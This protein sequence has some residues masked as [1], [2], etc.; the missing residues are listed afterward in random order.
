MITYFSADRLYWTDGYHDKIE[1]TDLNGG[2]RREILTDSSSHMMS[3]FVGGPY[4]YYTAW[5]RQ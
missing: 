5:S 2:D 1:S 4:I 3:V